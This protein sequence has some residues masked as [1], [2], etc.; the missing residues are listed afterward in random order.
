MSV[1]DNFLDF[2]FDVIFK[3]FFSCE[4]DVFFEFWKSYFGNLLGLWFKE[5]YKFN[6]V[7]LLFIIYYFILI[8]LMF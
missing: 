6:G 7:I 1:C 2:N 3:S 8:C 4:Y 5:E